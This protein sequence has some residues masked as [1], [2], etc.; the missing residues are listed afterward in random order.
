M[1]KS[2]HKSY[3]SHQTKPLGTKRKSFERDVPRI[4]ET[5]ISDSNESAISEMNCSDLEHEHRTSSNSHKEQDASPKFVSS[6]LIY[7]TN[8]PWTAT[9]KQV[10]EFL[11]GI[12]ILNGS[13][14]VHFTL[15]NTTNNNAFVQIATEDDYQLVLKEKMKTFTMGSRYSMVRGKTWFE[16]L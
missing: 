9:K 4:R 14:G 15:E 12:H 7:I 13:K 1:K 8:I 3:E 16:Y 10:V 11:Y 5:S 6:N 2:T